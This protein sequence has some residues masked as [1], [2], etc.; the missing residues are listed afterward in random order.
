MVYFV[1][2]DIP[3]R[4]NKSVYIVLISLLGFCSLIQ[5]QTYVLEAR[6]VEEGSGTSLSFVTVFNKTQLNGTAS[7]PDGFFVLPNNQLGD[8]IVVAFLGYQEKSFAVT[9]LMSDVITLSPQST[10]LGEIVVTAESD[11]LY[12]LVL[13]VRNQKRTKTKTSKTYFFLETL[14]YNEPIEIIEAYYN[15]AYSDHGIGTLKIKKGRIG[16]KPI[17][18]RYYRSTESSSLFS[19]HDVY[20]KSY[21]FPESPLALNKKELKKNY[22]LNLN[23]TFNTDQSEIYVIDI[24][25]KNERKDLFASTVWN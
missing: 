21:L 15:G 6:I 3:I 1:G 14:L 4:M 20:A 24:A 19:L 13:Q 23:Y 11:F 5:A 22:T 7:N 25:P 16:L 9:A 8:T 2:S 18:G 17:N 10:K 12:D